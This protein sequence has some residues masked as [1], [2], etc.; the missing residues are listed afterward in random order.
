M[1]MQSGTAP[2]EYAIRGGRFRVCDPYLGTI[3]IGPSGILLEQAQ[4]VITAERRKWNRLSAGG[5][6]LLPDFNIYI[7]P[8]ITP[9]G[10]YEPKANG[11]TLDNEIYPASA[12]ILDHI[13]EIRTALNNLFSNYADDCDLDQYEYRAAWLQSLYPES[14]SGNYS[15]DDPDT[16]INAIGHWTH[17]LPSETGNVEYLAHDVLGSSGVIYDIDFA[18]I[19]FNPPPHI[20]STSFDTMHGRRVSNAE[21]TFN[22]QQG[23]LFPA[24]QKTNGS[25]IAL[26]NREP[27]FLRSHPNYSINHISSGAIRLDGYVISSGT[28]FYIGNNANIFDASIDDFLSLSQGIRQ[29]LFGGNFPDARI[30]IIPK[31]QNSGIYRIAAVNETVDFPNTTIESGKMS[32]WPTL[33][34]YWPSGLGV[35]AT[36]IGSTTTLANLGYH[37]FDDAIWM[38]DVSPNVTGG[39][40]NH[41][42]GLA[43][44]SPFTGHRLWIRYAD[45][46]AGTHTQTG[47]PRMTGLERANTNVIY[48]LDPASITTSTAVSG[49]LLFTQYNDNLD[50]VVETPTTASTLFQNDEFP[51]GASSI[52][53]SDFFFDGTNYWV[54]NLNSPGFD[55]FK[56]TTSFDFV[57]KYSL[58]GIRGGR[59]AYVGGKQIVFYGEIPGGVGTFVNTFGSGIQSFV[60]IT[61]SSDPGG[62]TAGTITL[63]EPK[64]INGAPFIG[65]SSFAEIMD[66]FEVTGATHVPNGIYAFLLWTHQVGTN[67]RLYLVRIEEATSTWEIK[68]IARMETSVD[69]GFGRREFLYMPY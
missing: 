33:T 7:N 52:S 57:E 28:S 6:H 2:Y 4:F 39:L 25:V 14:T 31:T 49:K 67:S 46:T 64:Y 55:V 36:R 40:E 3:P 50:R 62:V 47:W 61:D 26:T 1:V 56:F 23:P 16:F 51:F 58:S 15:A 34:T 37:I 30:F 12:W 65:V 54:F 41:P 17:R 63:S 32:F 8:I 24:F 29:V 68:S 21:D 9:S 5:S 48:R 53:V 44:L 60:T 38:L 20:S 69:P 18:E 43:I 10:P 13:Q 22:I 35:D 45:V 59:G 11:S 66:V 27:T 19:M 42:S